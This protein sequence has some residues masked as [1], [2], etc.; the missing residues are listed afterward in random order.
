MFS[1]INKILWGRLSDLFYTIPEMSILN[2]KT[3]KTFINE[4]EIFGSMGIIC[5]IHCLYTLQNGQVYNV[6]FQDLSSETV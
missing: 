6:F 5:S 1:Q 4:Q 2:L 3:G